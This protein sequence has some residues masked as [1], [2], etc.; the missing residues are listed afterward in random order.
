[1]AETTIPSPL[2]QLVCNSENSLAAG[3]LKDPKFS[4]RK[5]KKEEICVEETRWV[6]CLALKTDFLP[7]F[8]MLGRNSPAVLGHQELRNTPSLHFQSLGLGVSWVC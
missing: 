7:E 6:S 3:V 5:N 1:M 2:E 4:T 8:T